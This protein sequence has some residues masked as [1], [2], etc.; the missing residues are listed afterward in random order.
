MHL[1][2]ELD[3]NTQS[4]LGCPIDPLETVSSIE[5]LFR[6]ERPGQKIRLSFCFKYSLPFRLKLSWLKILA[7]NTLF[8]H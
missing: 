7:L 1:V 5:A 8:T 4:L 6:S 2:R 3:R